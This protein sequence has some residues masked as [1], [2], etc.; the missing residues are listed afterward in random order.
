MAS[1][2]GIKDQNSDTGWLKNKRFNSAEESL[3]NRYRAPE[4]KR[5]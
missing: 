4:A 2:L 5:L 1:I 3:S